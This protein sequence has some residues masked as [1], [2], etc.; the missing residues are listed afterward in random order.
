MKIMN[1]HIR[2]LIN[3]PVIISPIDGLPMH[4]YIVEYGYI[5]TI[6]Y[7]SGKYWKNYYP[8]GIRLFYNLLKAYDFYKKNYSGIIGIAY[9]QLYDFMDDGD[10][11]IL[12]SCQGGNVGKRNIYV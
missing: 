9:M 10:K 3:E 5:D 1:D 6:F 8:I 7:E 11:E 12:F 4:L 2:Y